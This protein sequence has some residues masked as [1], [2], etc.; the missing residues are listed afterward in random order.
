MVGLTPHLY[1]NTHVGA[2]TPK[3][4]GEKGEQ[5]RLE[6]MKIGA[7][8]RAGRCR[9][10][11]VH[12]VPCR[13]LCLGRRGQRRPGLSPAAT[14][15]SRAR[16]SQGHMQAAHSTHC[17]QETTSKKAA[18][19]SPKGRRNSASVWEQHARGGRLP[20]RRGRGRGQRAED[21]ELLLLLWQRCLLRML[22]GV[23]Q[24]EREWS[25]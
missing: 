16:D 11:S 20:R 18:P 4:A 19:Q 22:K 24:S 14:G 25:K 6:E 8:L 10:C 7:R 5:V 17:G 23:S 13:A 15:A 1:T 3:R 9:K 2:H 21:G 12:R